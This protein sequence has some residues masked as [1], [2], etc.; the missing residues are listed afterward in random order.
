MIKISAT[1]GFNFFEPLLLQIG[2]DDELS[3]LGF[4]S[5]ETEGYNDEDWTD[6]QGDLS[7][8]VCLFWSVRS[9]Y[10]SS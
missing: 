5:D 10:N 2:E 3:C 7:G 9:Y 4:E 8:A 1:E 6:W